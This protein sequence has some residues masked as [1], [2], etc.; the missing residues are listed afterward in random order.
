MENSN[1]GLQLTIYSG[2]FAPV[3][4]KRQAQLEQGYN[5]I[6]YSDVPAEDDVEVTY[7][8]LYSY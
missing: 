4:E 7:T 8:S 2:N 1:S 3:K 5:Y 6:R